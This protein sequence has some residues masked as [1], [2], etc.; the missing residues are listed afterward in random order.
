MS[1]LPTQHAQLKIRWMFNDVA[2]STLQFSEKHSVSVPG[3]W[4]PDGLVVQLHQSLEFDHN[5][6]SVHQ[7]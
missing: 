3:V 5:H 4:R 6:T 1:L 2:L 7:N